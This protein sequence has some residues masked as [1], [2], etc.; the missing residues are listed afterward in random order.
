MPLINVVCLATRSNI[1]VSSLSRKLEMRLAGAWIEAMIG[2]TG[3][4]GY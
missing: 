3:I 4:L 2:R 1:G